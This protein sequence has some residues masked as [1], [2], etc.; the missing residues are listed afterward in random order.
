MKFIQLKTKHN[1]IFSFLENVEN[2]HNNQKELIKFR[3]KNNH[4][5]LKFPDI[6]IW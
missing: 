4:Q 6:K 1:K 5:Q 2:I 3:L